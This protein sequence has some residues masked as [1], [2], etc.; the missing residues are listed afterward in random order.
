MASASPPNV[1]A[2]CLEL[3][4]RRAP[5][6]IPHLTLWQ[7][8]VLRD[9][10]RLLMLSRNCPAPPAAPSGAHPSDRAALSA[11]S[12]GPCS[13]GE[14]PHSQIAYRTTCAAPGTHA[15]LANQTSC[16]YLTHMIGDAL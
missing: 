5:D 10:V 15:T 16:S 13:G 11:L 2:A 12:T 9:Q 1:W 14:G 7:V 8:L 3:L 4:Q 6:A